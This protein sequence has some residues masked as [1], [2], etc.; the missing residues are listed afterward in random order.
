LEKSL[1]SRKSTFVRHTVHHD[2]LHQ[3]SKVTKAPLFI[4]THV[5]L[6]LDTRTTALHLRFAPDEVAFYIWKERMDNTRHHG[7]DFICNKH[8]PKANRQ[9]KAKMPSFFG[10]KLS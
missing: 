2:L 5:V 7:A 3:G 6:C 4:V 9:W 10:L 1:S 8:D